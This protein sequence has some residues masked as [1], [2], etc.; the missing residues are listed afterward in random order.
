MTD[1]GKRLVKRKPPSGWC[2]SGGGRKDDAGRE[3][4][5]KEDLRGEGGG[6]RCDLWS[7]MAPCTFVASR[8]AAAATPS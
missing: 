1:A 6:G 8:R 7:S 4:R 5:A 2:M 3:M